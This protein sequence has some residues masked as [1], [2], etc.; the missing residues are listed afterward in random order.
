[1]RFQLAIASLLCV[2]VLSGCRENSFKTEYTAEEAAV[3]AARLEREMAEPLYQEAL[4]YY[5]TGEYYEAQQRFSPLAEAGNSMA[6]L[7]LWRCNTTGSKTYRLR[8]TQEEFAYMTWPRKDASTG[9]EYTSP[10]ALPF[11]FQAAEQDNPYAMN[12]MGGSGSEEDWYARS[13]GYWRVRAQ[14]ANDADAWY[15]LGV[16]T[17][18]NSD[19]SWPVIREHYFKGAL[20]G[21]EAATYSFVDNKEILELIRWEKLFEGFRIKYPN[22]EAQY[23]AALKEL[24]DAGRPQ[25]QYH[26]AKL[27]GETSYLI[28]AARQNLYKAWLELVSYYAWGGEQKCRTEETVKQAAFLENTRLIYYFGAPKPYAEMNGYY[29]KYEARTPEECKSKAGVVKYIISPDEYD[30]I[31]E[32]AKE[33]LRNNRFITFVHPLGW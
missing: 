29:I 27:T 17:Y 30:L 9:Y 5:M 22:W 33:W 21:S 11:L 13:P 28:L 15:C 3:I 14:A 1:M 18:P 32:S 12:F 16:K 6:A 4:R 26:Y 23:F 10:D 20:A 19:E 24:A 8:Q 25:A 7:Y 31:V 2:L